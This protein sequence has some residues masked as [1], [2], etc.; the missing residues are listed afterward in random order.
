MRHFS[1]LMMFICV[2]M[3]SMSIW[4][5]VTRIPNVTA[6]D[7]AVVGLICLVIGAGSHSAVREKVMKE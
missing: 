1:T 7:Y 6:G 2:G 4:D 3:F 5:I